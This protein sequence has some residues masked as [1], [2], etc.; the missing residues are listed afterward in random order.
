[1]NTPNKL[2]QQTGHANEV[3]S[4]FR[5]SLRVSRLLSLVTMKPWGSQVTFLRFCLR[6]F[7]RNREDG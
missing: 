5:V 4:S 2:L 7:L 3:S 6:F 1:M